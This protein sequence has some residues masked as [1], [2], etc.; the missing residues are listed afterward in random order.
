MNKAI[1]IIKQNLKNESVV[2]ATSGGPDSMTLLEL[3]NS[4]KE[5]LNLKLICAH[6]NHKIREESDEEETMVKEYCKKNNISCKILTI[7]NY[8]DDNFHKCVKKCKAKHL[9]TAHHGDDLTETIL[10]RLVRGST[11][12]GYAGFEEKDNRENYII[13][14]P[15]INY[16]KDEILEY[17]KRNK[18]KF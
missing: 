7:D 14:R 2:I 9:L 12:K 3:V 10:M 18:I 8:N 5:E 6:V 1:N 4:L 16:T 15:L 11:L 13:L 17:A